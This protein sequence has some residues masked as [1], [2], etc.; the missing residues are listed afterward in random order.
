M[1]SGSVAVRVSGG[2]RLEWRH[3]LALVDALL[4]HLLKRG[5]HACRGLRLL[6][7]DLAWLRSLSSRSIGSHVGLLAGLGT[8]LVR[9]GARPGT[10][11]GRELGLGSVWVWGQG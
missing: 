2:E 3:C 4:H 1:G 7:A 9:V 5:W 6:V 10:R 11:L 8:R